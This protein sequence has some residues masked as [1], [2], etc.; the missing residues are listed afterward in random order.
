MD[1]SVD[2][3]TLPS[4]FDLTGRVAIVT[5]AGSGIGLG[6]SQVLAAAG[7]LVVC[8][9]VNDATAD[10]AAGAIGSAGYQARAATL[11]VS[12]RSD[13]ADLIQSTAA[14]YGRLDIMCNNAGLIGPEVPAIDLTEEALDALLA[15][16]LKGVLFGSQ[17]A[18]KAMVR[19]G[20]GS[21]VNTASAA[22]DS[23]TP[24]LLAYGISKVGIVQISRSLAAEVGPS[25]VRVNVVAPGLVET[26]ITRHHYTNPDGTTD[27]ARR[28]ATLTQMREYAPLKTLGLPED[29]GLAVLFLASD[30]SR[31]ITG[32]ILRP[33]GGTAMPW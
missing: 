32:Q 23:P 16:N 24:S 5:G 8:A 33:N 15:V 26:N 10:A 13:V 6:I 18:A 14:E 9:D 31:F 2:A 7:A 1:W 28:D 30:A 4:A 3:A 22:I 19:Q 20:R 21:I 11:D 17:E 27:E 29:I 12:H 25:G